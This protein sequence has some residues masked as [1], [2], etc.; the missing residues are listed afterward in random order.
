MTNE[1]IQQAIE[2]C[3]RT[4][5][6]ISRWYVGIAGAALFAAFAVFGPVIVLGAFFGFMLGLGVIGLDIYKSDPSSDQ[7][8]PASPEKKP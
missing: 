5:R 2:R 4:G 7:P 8:L 1:E 3:N 6:S